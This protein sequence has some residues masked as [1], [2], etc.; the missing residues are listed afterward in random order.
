VETERPAAARWHPGDE[1]AEAAA[2]QGSGGAWRG[3]A[4][5]EVPQ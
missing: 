5:G 3:E 4:A 1:G 2:T